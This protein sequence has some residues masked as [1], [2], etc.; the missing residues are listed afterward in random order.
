[1]A[2]ISIADILKDAPVNSNEFRVAL[3]GL[4]RDT[5]QEC[6]T[7]L[8]SRTWTREELDRLINLLDPCRVT[9]IFREYLGDGPKGVEPRA[10]VLRKALLPHLKECGHCSFNAMLADVLAPDEKSPPA[11][12]KYN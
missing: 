11:D 6:I 10:A 7:A 3:T 2:L 9:A 5:L 4:N 1:M 12:K 8:Q